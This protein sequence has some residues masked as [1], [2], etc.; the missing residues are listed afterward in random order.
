MNKTS[1][2]LGGGAEEEL[3][4]SEKEQKKRD[5]GRGEFWVDLRVLQQQNAGH[6]HWGRKQDSKPSISFTTT[7]AHRRQE[8]DISK[9]SS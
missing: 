4:L 8:L 1:G 2:M 6:P 3:R 7:Q 9:P 5:A